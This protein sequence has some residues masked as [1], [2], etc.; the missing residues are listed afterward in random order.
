MTKGIVIPIMERYEELLINNIHV[1]RKDLKCKLPIELWQI[2]QEVSDNIML[3]LNSLKEE[4]NLSFQ[5][6]ANYTEDPNHWKGWQIKAFIV[7]N[8]KFD[9]IILC[10]CDSVFLVNPEIIFTDHNYLR[11]GTYF[12][13]DW[14][15]HEPANREIEIPA[16][17]AFIRKLL[18][19]KKRYFPEEW[20]YIY[21]LP[22]TVQPMWY[23]QESGVVYLNKTMHSDV[24][25]TIYLLNYT[26]QETYKY[27]YGD[28]ETFWL[29]FVI[30][31]KPF[32]MNEVH[33]ENY[34]INPKL[35]YFINNI[36]EVPNAFC[37]FYNKKF[38]F[39]Q[40]GYPHIFVTKIKSMAYN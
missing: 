8:T 19:Y 6:V 33:A 22:D 21:D 2:G 32:F 35:P 30:H 15:K 9:E 18:P 3:I 17:Q 40:K 1:L 16:R 14:I 36:N 13:K 25:E 23:Y 39:S 28:K 27:L 12:F 34:K 31:D 4:Y 7:K 26:H 20:N 37:H 38:F 5:N 11:T 29:S 10:D 24:I